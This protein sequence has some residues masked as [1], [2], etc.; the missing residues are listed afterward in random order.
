MPRTN[1]ETAINSVSRLRSGSIEANRLKAAFEPLADLIPE[2]AQLQKILPR[3]GVVFVGQ[4]SGRASA[5]GVLSGLKAAGRFGRIDRARLDRELGGIYVDANGNVH[6]TGSEPSTTTPSEPTTTT[7]ATDP[8]VAART[9]EGRSFAADVLA[10]GWNSLALPMPP[11]T[12]EAIRLSPA[13]SAKLRDIFSDADKRAGFKAGIAAPPASQKTNSERWQRVL[14]FFPDDVVRQRAHDAVTFGSFT[15]MT[16]V[17]YN[18]V[19][20]LGK[21]TDTVAVTNV[22]YSSLTGPQPSEGEKVEAAGDAVSALVNATWH[23]DFFCTKA[24]MTHDQAQLFGKGCKAFGPFIREL[25]TKMQ[26]EEASA[27]SSGESSDSS[28][29]KQIVGTILVVLGNIISEVGQAILNTDHG[30]GIVLLTNFWF[31][32]LLTGVPVVWPESR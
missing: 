19:P 2:V 1:I 17:L 31:G 3:E 15:G 10:L 25:G 4:P 6:H 22:V 12:I 32:I 27:S 8:A 5:A 29:A 9:L 11:L 16:A 18:G 20:I 26:Q 28:S 21:Q 24:E 30:K 14:A 23:H 7:P 13:H